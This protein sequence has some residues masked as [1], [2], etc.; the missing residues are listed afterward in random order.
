MHGRYH[1]HFTLK[2]HDLIPAGFCIEYEG[3]PN[4]KGLGFDDRIVDLSTNKKIRILTPQA[5][6]SLVKALDQIDYI[7]ENIFNIRSSFRISESGIALI[8]H[9][10]FKNIDELNAVYDKV[11]DILKSIKTALSKT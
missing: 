6:E 3:N 1:T 10:L 7:D 9:R 2:Y 8:V 5:K 4:T 11:F